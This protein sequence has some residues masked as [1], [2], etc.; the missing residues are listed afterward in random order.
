[1]SWYLSENCFGERLPNFENEC[2]DEMYKTEHTCQKYFQVAASKSFHF[3]PGN[4]PVPL[5]LRM[6]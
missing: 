4:R 5:K 2:N 3:V 6:R 1:M